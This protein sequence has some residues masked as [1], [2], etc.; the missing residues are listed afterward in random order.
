MQQIHELKLPA[1]RT[2]RRRWY[3]RP[4]GAGAASPRNDV[5]WSSPR[6]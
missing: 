1:P 6:L 5:V 2:R 4:A 3:D